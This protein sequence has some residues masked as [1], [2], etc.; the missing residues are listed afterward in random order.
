MTETRKLAA[1]LVTDVVGYSRLAG[2]DEERTRA[3]LRGL[4]SDLIDPAVAAHHGRIVKRTGDGSIS[5]FR[6]CRD[7]SGG[8]PV[9]CH[10]HRQELQRLRLAARGAP[11][12][13]APPGEQQIGVDAVAL[14]HLRHRRAGREARGSD[15]TRAGQMRPCGRGRGWR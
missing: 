9:L 4:S 3:R 10:C 12:L 2:T 14:R 7:R 6:R 13:L 8:R 11:R 15:R 1:I 5:E